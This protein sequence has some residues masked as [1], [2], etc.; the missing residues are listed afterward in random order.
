MVL[1]PTNKRPRVALSALKPISLSDRQFLRLA[2]E[3][4][5]GEETIVTAKPRESISAEYHAL[6]R[7]CQDIIQLVLED[8]R[9][10]P[11]LVQRPAKLFQFFFNSCP[12][13]QS[14]V[15]ICRPKDD[16]WHMVFYGD[17]ITP[18][19]PLK[20]ANA[21]K[22]YCFYISFRE[23]GKY[24]SDENSWLPVAVL[25]HS[26]VSKLPGGLS[27]AV[28]LL[29]K[30]AFFGHVNFSDGFQL[31]DF[32]IKA[33][34]SNILGDEAALKGIWSCKGAA[35]VKPCMCCKNVISK[36]S[37][38]V[39][40]IDTS[41]FV[42]LDHTIVA[43]FDLNT[44]NDIWEVIDN[45]A[46]QQPLL[47]KQRFDQLQKCLG[48]VHNPNGLLADVP[49]RE[50]V[51]PIS[52]HTWDF[53]HTFLQGGVASVECLLFLSACRQKL[54]VRFSHIAAFC[55][56]DWS[57]QDRRALANI[58]QV[59]SD[60]RESCTH[61]SF[62][63]NASELLS[64]L[65]LLAHF[66]EVTC[67]SRADIQNELESL[68]AAADIVRCIIRRLSMFAKHTHTQSTRNCL[69]MLVYL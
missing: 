69:K 38:V 58:K 35:G 39:E 48:F 29:L 1:L 8:G 68:L 44:D 3:L 66:A 61:D 42:T 55:D 54:G 25:R 52:C 17:E 2:A 16:K 12:A 43:D 46:L 21:R 28:K 10:I 5:H 60:E 36:N 51:K 65:P 18:G 13:F 53:M 15:R 34:L 64:A 47:N 57:F 6:A 11:W 9:T 49:L 23:F 40:Y 20:P 37:S 59:F 27:Q 45:M 22:V 32:S 14:L 50:H 19:N 7:T 63:G 62:K 41:Y 56:A 30:T 31:S 67:S 4:S 33:S 24:I 26:V